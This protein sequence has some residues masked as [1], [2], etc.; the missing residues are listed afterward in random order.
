MIAPAVLV[1]VAGVEAVM[2]GPFPPSM[3]VVR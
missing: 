3:L 2:V 1:I